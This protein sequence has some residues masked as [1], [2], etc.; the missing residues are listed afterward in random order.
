MVNLSATFRY[1]IGHPGNDR[2]IGTLVKSHMVRSKTKTKKNEEEIRKYT[3]NEEEEK[4][5]NNPN[6]D[7]MP[8][9]GHN[10]GENH[11]ATLGTPSREGVKLEDFVNGPTKNVKPRRLG[12]WT[13]K[14]YR[15]QNESGA[16]SDECKKSSNEHGRI[17]GTPGR[18]KT[19]SR[20]DKILHWARRLCQT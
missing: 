2:I 11:H 4:E 6:S 13:E 9:L 3:K 14:A 8:T 20:R 15:S 10:K 7:E 5:H 1:D 17:R 16:R 19:A 12:V 18:E